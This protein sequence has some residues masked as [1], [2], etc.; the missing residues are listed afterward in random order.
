VAATALY[1]L[2]RPYHPSSSKPGRINVYVMYVMRGGT[3]GGIMLI[4]VAVVSPPYLLGHFLDLD[5]GSR[6]CMLGRGSLH[7]KEGGLAKQEDGCALEMKSMRLP[8]RFILGR[9]LNFYPLKSQSKGESK[10]EGLYKFLLREEGG[11]VASTR[12]KQG[13]K[14]SARS[15]CMQTP[16]PRHATQVKS[17]S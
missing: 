5:K 8:N 13:V 7:N 4:L 12:P 3:M 10:G 9:V 6:W 17:I 14:P 15:R 11:D 16:K 2:L 1:E